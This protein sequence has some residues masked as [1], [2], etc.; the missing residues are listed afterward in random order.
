MQRFV[1]GF[2]GEDGKT[3]KK[4][5]V[6]FRWFCLGTKTH[7]KKET[8]EAKLIRYQI[9]LGKVLGARNAAANSLK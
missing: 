6:D 9:Q 5:F 3:L 8:A 4:N 2:G 1:A 7:K